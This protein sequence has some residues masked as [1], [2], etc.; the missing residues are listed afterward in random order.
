MDMPDL[1]IAPARLPIA[2]ANSQPAGAEDVEALRRL[3]VE[4][5]TYAT[6]RDP[7]VA[8]D[9]DWFVATALA[10]RDR[11]VDRWLASTR[12]DTARHR[13]RVY[14]LSLEFLPGRLLL[15]SLNNSWLTEPMRL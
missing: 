11:I 12:N 6:G 14:Y 15:D 9:R 1:F 13:K 3:I 2:P 10:L 8:S 7:L 5:L 4:K